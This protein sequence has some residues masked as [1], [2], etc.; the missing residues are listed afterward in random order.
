MVRGG[1]G[2]LDGVAADVVE[3]VVGGC[4]CV[5][6]CESWGVDVVWRVWHRWSR[7]WSYT[8]FISFM[9]LCFPSH[10]DENS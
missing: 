9:C 4:W 10:E 6:G 3:C 5:E 8:P 1:L 2:A 7:V